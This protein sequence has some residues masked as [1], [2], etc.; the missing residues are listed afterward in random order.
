MA[1]WR[2]FFERRSPREASEGFEL[3]DLNDGA[4]WDL[5]LRL[6]AYNPGDRISA[7]EALQHPAFGRS[8]LSRAVRTAVNAGGEALQV[9]NLGLAVWL[10]QP[11]AGVHRMLWRLGLAMLVSACVGLQAECVYSG[12]DT[13]RW[14]RSV[15]LLADL[16]HACLAAERMLS[17][18]Q[19]APAGARTSCA[20]SRLTLPDSHGAL[21]YCACPFLR[22]PAAA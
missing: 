7:S 16:L 11:S 19:A 21:Q 2:R 12:G 3:L 8:A 18:A 10:Q 22:S 5:T 13:S 6:M 4:L 15:L 20:Q 1:Q 9:W 17:S 14:L